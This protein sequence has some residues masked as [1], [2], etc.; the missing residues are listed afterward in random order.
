MVKFKDF[1]EEKI[2]EYSLE[3]LKSFVNEV[4]MKKSVIMEDYASELAEYLGDDTFDVYSLKG[5]KT[6]K[7]IAKKYLPQIAGA[8]EYLSILH[9]EIAKREQYEEEMR[10][11]GRSIKPKKNESM[12]E[13]LQKEQDKTWVYRSKID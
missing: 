3:N 12:E 4:E 7:K 13:F 9:A 1:N 11:S 2:V 5:N 6:I 10:Y 8:D